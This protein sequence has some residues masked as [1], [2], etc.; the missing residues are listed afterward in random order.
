MNHIYRLCW[1]RSLARWVVTSELSRRATRGSGPRKRSAK[2]L[3]T[4]ALAVLAS[5]AYTAWAGPTGGQIVTGSGQILQSGSTTTIQQNS[6]NLS[7]NWQSFNVGAQETVRFVQPNANSLAVN[8]IFSAS[9]SEI[10]GHLNANGQVWLINPN[11][12]LFGQQAQVNVGGLVA[13]TLDLVDDPGSSSDTRKFR[14]DS[15]ASVVNKG[16]ITAAPGGY[17]A[18][19]GHQV[20]NQ[21]VI[22]AQLGTVALGAGSA[23]TLTFSGN[24]LLHLQVDQSALNDLV[25]NGK[26]IEANGGQVF[27]TAGAKDSVLASVVNNTGVIQA[28]TV[29]NHN[30]TIVLLGGGAG[31]ANVDGTLD[32]SA[33]AGGNGG[34]IETSGATVNINP[35]ATI[36]ASAP[37]GRAGTWLVDP[38][39]LTIDS[40]A[41]A[42]IR[43]SLNNG[44]NV[45]EQT[46]ATTAS[47]AGQINNSGSGNITVSSAIT[48]SNPATTLTLDAYNAID[49]NAMINGSGQVVMTAGGNITLGAASP[50]L[51]QAGVTLKTTANFIN[52]AGAGAISVGSGARWLVYSTN[53]TQ[54]TTGGLAPSFIQYNATGG[55][56]PTP[57]TGSGFLYSVAPSLTV[58]ALSGT[59]T[60]TYDGT[61][62]APLTGSN[63]TATGLLN[64]D[65]IA[66]ATGTFSS[67]NAGSGLTVTAPTDFSTFVLVNGT[68]PVY[69]YSLASSTG[70]TTGTISPKQLTASIIQTPTKVYDGTTTA[71]LSSSNYR[72]D[73]F[74]GTQSAT[75][76]QASSVAY[77]S[78]DANQNAVVNATFTSTN[79]TA[80]S[81]TNFANYILP[82]SATGA[83]IIN[84]ASLNL[85]GLLALDKTYDGTNTAPLNTSNA[86]L[87]GVIAPDV[88]HV[89]LDSS[90]ALATF[91]QSNAGNNLAVN[92]NSTS[93][94]LTG[95]KSANYTLVAPGN[96]T[97]NIG[98][99]GVTVNNVTGTDKVYNGNSSDT[100][101]FGSA[102]LSNVLPG[103]ASNVI[104]VTGS[105]T[106]TFASSNA[107]SNIG[108]SVSGLTLTGTA[109]SNY[110]I[111]QPTGLT[112]NITAAPLTIT[113]GGAQSKSYNGTTTATVPGTDFTITGFIGSE[114]ATITQNASADYSSPNAGTHLGVTAILEVSD[115]TA[116]SGTLMSNYSIP[117]TVSSTNT[118]T[119]TAIPLSAQ[120]TGN[121]TKTYDGNTDATLT[122]GNYV[123]TGF[124]GSESATI[125]QTSGT[126]AAKDVGPEGVTANVTSGNYVAG[127][128]TLLS[129]YILP[130]TITGQGTIQPAPLGGHISGSIVGNPT[131]PYDGNDLAALT[132]ANYDLTGFA[133]GD[134]ATVTQTVGHYATVNAAVQG[135]TVNL[136]NGDFSPTGGTNLSNYILP[137]VLYGTGTIAPKQLT[138]SIIG[139]PTK[140]YDGSRVTVLAPSNYQ[141]TGFAGS[142]GA[143]INDSSLINYDT[144]NVG[145]Q[146]ITAQ[147]TTSSFTANGGTLLSNY[148]LPT[149]ATGSGTITAAP[150]YVLGVVANNKTYD[151]T[152][153][154]TLNIG[155]VALGGLVSGESSVVTLNTSTSGFFSQV[156]VSN[157]VG[158]TATGFA[159]SGSGAGNY[160]LQPITGLK[161]NI[162]PA[163]LTIQLVTA[164]GK[165]YDG[166]S[167]ATLN[168]GSAQLHGI[169]GSDNV[170][171]DSSG[172][173]ATFSSVNAGTAIP[174]SA[175]GFTLGGTK[176]N[177]YS[178]SQ[179][180]GLSA[181]ISRQQITAT[182]IGNPTKPYDGSN[183]ATLTNSDYQLTGFASGEGATVPQSAT[184]NYS[185]AN[186]GNHRGLE[187]TLVIS[188]FVPNSGTNLSNYIMPNTA[189]GIL[190]TI[191]P[192]ILDLNATRVYDS[193]AN[194]VGSLFGNLTGLNG[195]ILTVSGTGTGILASK[196]VGTQSFLSQG[197]L[198]LVATGSAIATN[199]TLVGGSDHVT[200]TPLA[201]TVTGTTGATRG[202]NGLTDIAIS[203]ATLNGVISGDDVTLGNDS[204]G[205][206]YDKNVG[207]NKPI[208]TAMTLNGND[209]TNYTLTQPTDAK[210]TVT[211]QHITV[212]ASGVDRQYDATVVDHPTY[213]S[214]GVLAGDTVNFSGNATFLTADVGNNK[215]VSVIGIT[216]GGTDA[217]N[218]I[219]DNTTTSTT[220]S[221][222]PKVLDLIGTRVYDG[223]T[224]VN[225]TLFGDHNGNLTG[226]GGQT[227]VL[228]LSSG[229]SQK[230]VG[231]RTFDPSTFTLSNGTGN[232]SN[233][234]LI[235]GTDKV[236]ITKADLVVTGTTVT[237]KTYDGSTDAQL[238]GATITAIGAD[239]VNLHNNTHGTFA[240]KDVGS[241]ITVT[242]D[243]MTIDG[244]DA[245]D[246]NLIQPTLSGSISSKSLTVTA[247]GLN[248]AYNGL[249]TANITLGSSD[250]ATGDTVTYSYGS[251]SFSDRN[252]NNNIPISVSGISIGGASAGDY[253]LANTTA[254]TFA[255]I[256]QAI[257]NL[258]ATRVY[259]GLST[260]NAA[261]FGTNG[262]LNGVNGE[263]LTLTGV[264]SLPGKDVGNQRALTLGTLQLTDGSGLASNYQ[265]GNTNWVTIT[266][267]H[268][269]VGANGLN[270]VYDG[271]RLDP[272]LTLTS[273]GIL[274]GDTVTFADTSALFNDKTANT[275]KLISVSGISISGGAQASDYA[276]DNTTATTHA[277]ITQKP[278]TITVSS[279][280]KPYDGNNSAVTALSAGVGGIVSG[281]NVNINDTS[282]TFSDANAHSN[283]TVTASG[284]SLSGTDAGNYSLNNTLATTTADITQAIIN[285]SGS[286][287][288]D[289]TANT[290]AGMF[291][292]NGVINGVNGETLTLTGTGSVLNKNV[293]ASEALTSLG[294][295]N[296]NNSNYTLIGGADTATITP[297]H[298]TVDANGINKVYDG[299]SLDPGLF[300]TSNGI[301]GSDIVHFAATSALFNDKT[302]NT[303]KAISV[304][305]ISISGGADAN[306]YT[307]DN[308][309]A[310]THADITQKPLTITVSSNNKVYDGTN[311]ATTALSAGIGG[312]VS[313]DH[314]D[315]N[316][317]SATFS[318]AN[319]HTGKTVT[320]S[321]ISLSGGDAGNY[322]LN[323]T[324]ATTTADITQAIINLSGAR[325][326]DGTANAAAAMF[327]NNGVINGVNGETLT[328]TGTGSLPN[329]NISASEALASLGSLDL[330]NGNYTLTGGT[331]TA[332]VTPLHILATAS[333]VNKTYDGNRLDPGYTV[334]SAGILSGDSVTLGNTGAQF[335]DKNAGNGKTVTVSGLAITGGTDAGNYVLDNATAT[336]TANIAPLAI[337]V[338][339]TG[340]NKV[341]D[342]NTNDVVALAANGILSG[343]SVAFTQSS[344]TFDDKNVANGK[345]VTARGILATGADADNYSFNSVATTAANITPA[346][347]T[348][349]NTQVAN[350]AYDGTTAAK[351]VGANLQG[352]LGNDSITLANTT[353]GVFANANAGNAKGVTTN[354]TLT[355]SDAGNYTL[356]QPTALTG[357][358][359]PA[360]LNLTGTRQYDTTTGA[361]AGLFGNNSVL[362]GVNGE[363]LTLSGNG[364]LSS[365][366]VS[367]AQTFASLSGF[368]L[369]GNGSALASNYTLA[370][371]TDWVK[372]TPAP[373]TVINAAASNKVYDGNT[374][375]SISGASL[376]GALTG[377]NVVLGDDTTGTFANSNAGNGK[378]VTTSMTISGADAGN[379]TIAQP[380]AVAA[381]ITPKPLTIAAAGAN[382]TYDG[383][384]TAKVTLASSDVL[385]G[386]NVS[387]TDSSANFS[388][389]TVGN[390]KSVMVKGIQL[391][392]ADAGNYVIANDTA[393]AEADI[394]AGLSIQ[395]TATAVA[396]LAASTDAI[397]TPYGVAPSESPGPLTGNRKMVHRPVERNRARS[398][399]RSGL[400][401]QV[402][403]GGVRMP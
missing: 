264:G 143:S 371:G 308:T 288:Y 235:G 340:T 289:G 7:L 14:G 227:L 336:T 238:T 354:M 195:D 232:A 120:I 73:G 224:L 206:F 165:P 209:H 88:G 331:Y 271:T 244:L 9:G 306:N 147:L 199:Y 24:H 95:D 380:T 179:P 196:N 32:A 388:T 201:L 353:A 25:E 35:S 160:T 321:G 364:I 107:A 126:Y 111:S 265:V 266:P 171:L 287:V 49:V 351:L 74:V 197:D 48:W 315:I 399:F 258:Q 207:T 134:G 137:S 1:N 110:S 31:T 325:V 85:T 81:G 245:L 11:G 282:A 392:G 297:L 337:T 153:S 397:A 92:V 311:S 300:L 177:D 369:T 68:V 47:G 108:V 30:G 367:S 296:L 378:S 172:A 348:V 344:A 396:Y 261:I 346:P 349:V 122:S 152:N 301:V 13:S 356:A 394:T 298:I 286:R 70:S 374:S 189:S 194:A 132:S 163:P 259:N 247:T 33:P 292:N 77:A 357:N 156:D 322:S 52:N 72:I 45:T 400:S 42:S 142:E 249:Y 55:T 60:K 83:G 327:G 246:Y 350:K 51:G 193:T 36:T 269:T 375:A 191:T 125:N 310:T 317:T 342:A 254:S 231:T 46:T 360:I 358:I 345:T 145:L 101:N 56:S 167:A 230:D 84:K 213:T 323:N 329:K 303:N 41:A 3:Q 200:I 65:T 144:K 79:F 302:A 113:L 365:K 80:G 390:S 395:D 318:D 54:D 220:A 363:S 361:T 362:A 352:T 182:I 106:G 382:K 166:T 148:I 237:P 256:T 178:V 102:S 283:K 217:G 270:K 187:S 368:T 198:A 62:A 69:G 241:G 17:V 309:T 263:T 280:N 304:S 12:V 381:N 184:A 59:P 18:L 186:A 16:N 158:V 377:D 208:I 222:T 78:A 127:N 138:A 267:L 26:L 240:S 146:G 57:A 260:A 239:V 291:G 376:S 128:G 299:N 15:S 29:E 93:F 71:A 112:A 176:A 98:R 129:N 293:S 320:A 359:T 330:N 90:G 343:D 211:A 295:L 100:L 22:R 87:F 384:T 370:G 6:Q 104:L 276:I 255:N 335:A 403:D 21:G 5:G 161:A 307:I 242:T 319:A 140:V 173:S 210:G 243:P 103:D 272:G 109:A 181:D 82:T 202:Y 119:I 373:L 268:I 305:G 281:D 223:T 39:D 279:N 154:A 273:A 124:I 314:V 212:T 225:Y 4:T 168:T 10:L 63:M 150:L 284:I 180:S 277:D 174:V 151:T 215:P 28:Q 94:Q 86:G 190:G 326:Y 275:N 8:R 116:A 50:V 34:S 355:G 183:S 205:N 338:T 149:T 155:N 313:G 97:A 285:L 133:P 67:A 157:A 379:Y 139:S 274:S 118:G 387:F 99:R 218:Y 185:T 339:A 334:G 159:I 372:I 333:G 386:D 40:T 253:T 121:P 236:T 164:N 328:L 53:P 294:N 20:S 391:T 130:T 91:S 316:D 192:K 169:L 216:A 64:G 257:I 19:M 398:D 228:G 312:I 234:T 66:A 341:Y 204:T 250:V 89:A 251:A 61:T 105:A 44:T 347:L 383:N 203:G 23:Q 38:K 393:V 27:M 389:A 219:L 290:G 117:H 131:K 2:L 58:T 175:S 401:L 324:I 385:N 402:V 115:F 43:T 229:A 123:L 75:I 162:T 248:R 262:T 37:G 135:I 366:N 114:S 226:V 278:L 221:I 141:L 96:L 170:T 188:D 332:T 214:A 76:G 136:T 233:Y 252:V